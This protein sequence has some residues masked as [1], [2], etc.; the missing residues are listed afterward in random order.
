MKYSLL[1]SAKSILFCGY[2]KFELAPK[3]SPPSHNA[4]FIKSLRKCFNILT[5]RLPSYI[6]RVNLITH[7]FAP[8]PSHFIFNTWCLMLC[9]GMWDD[10]LSP[11]V[12]CVK[13]CWL[14]W[15]GG[16]IINSRIRVPLSFSKLQLQLSPECF[17]FHFKTPSRFTDELICSGMCLHK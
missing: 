17:H 12:G 11:F 10:Q 4:V 3:A 2:D 6:I 9:I 14:P 8:V 1:W 16:I 5:N 7:S 15:S 13:V